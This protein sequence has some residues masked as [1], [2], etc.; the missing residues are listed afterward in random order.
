M[1]IVGGWKM[2]FLRFKPA[3]EISQKYKE[4]FFNFPYSRAFDQ[5]LI[6]LNTETIYAKLKYVQIGIFILTV[7][8][9]N[10]DHSQ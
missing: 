1:G 7:V 3:M 4:F 8:F 6:K 10:L 5:A 2:L 9:C